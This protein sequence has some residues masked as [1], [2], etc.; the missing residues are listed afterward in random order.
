MYVLL[1]GLAGLVIGP[2]VFAGPAMAPAGPTWSYGYLTFLVILAPA[3]M[4]SQGGSAAGAAFW[5]R[6][7]MFVGATIYGVGAVFVFD[8]LWRRKPA[9]DDQ[10]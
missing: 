1:I 8:T 9:G 2:R 6:L 5:T 7:G 3:V 10:S 4:D